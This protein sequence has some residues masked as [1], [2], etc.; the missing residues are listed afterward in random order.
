MQRASE[1]EVA[2]GPKTKESPS[3]KRTLNLSQA[4]IAAQR[5]PHRFYTVTRFENLFA[6]KTSKGTLRN[7]KDY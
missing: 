6:K 3:K 4:E 2:A 7:N 5:D 1:F